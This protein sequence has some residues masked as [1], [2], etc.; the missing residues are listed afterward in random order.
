VPFSIPR[1][2]GQHHGGVS[3]G[4]SAGEDGR[5]LTGV[6]VD[7]AKTVPASRF[8]APTEFP[9]PECPLLEFVKISSMGAPV[10]M[11]LSKAVSSSVADHC[12]VQPG[13][14]SSALMAT[15]KYVNSIDPEI[16]NSHVCPW[17]GPTEGCRH[18]EQAYHFAGKNEL[19]RSQR[20][21]SLAIAR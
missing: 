13:R 19:L 20:R 21:I 2:G 11:T 8:L 9:L 5:C 3:T 4:P 17:R 12:V 16:L 14:L 1:A 18:S 15:A 10:I 7:N 6:Q